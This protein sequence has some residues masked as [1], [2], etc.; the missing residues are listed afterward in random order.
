MKSP[1]LG[2]QTLSTGLVKNDAS[3]ENGSMD[4]TKRKVKGEPVQI[5]NVEEGSNEHI[6]TLD[7]DAL[8][9]VLCQKEIKDKPVCIVSVAG[10]FRKG[11]SFLLNFLLRFLRAKGSENWLRSSGDEFESTEGFDWKGGSNRVTTGILMWSE[12]FTIETSEGEVAVVLLDTQGC[13]DRRSSVKDGVT[14]FALS[15]LASSVLIYNLDDNIQEDDLE[16][17]DFLTEY[18]RLALEEEGEAPFQKLSLL[19]R[20]WACP[21]DYAY[22]SEGGE[23]YRKFQWDVKQEQNKDRREHLDKC[24]SEISCF[25]LPDPGKSV[26][27]NPGKSVNLNDNE[28]AEFLKHLQDFIPAIF[29]PEALKMKKVG[30]KVVKCKDMVHYF[31]TYMDILTG[32]DMPE[33]KS[34]LDV[35][36]EANNLVSKASA[37]DLYMDNMEEFCGGRWYIQKK[38]MDLE[39]ECNLE[40]A[41]KEFDSERNMGGKNCSKEY[42]DELTEEIEEAYLHF[43][44]NNEAR[45][46][47][48]PSNVFIMV[49]LSWGILYIVSQVVATSCSLQIATSCSLQ[50]LINCLMGIL[51]AVVI[52]GAYVKYAGKYPSFGWMLPSWKKEIEDV[53]HSLV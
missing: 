45:N 51:F 50:I 53:G 5:V 46:V 39:H 7:E 8:K 24:F 26:N 37:L 30:G 34:L 44:T 28:F 38:K 2:L 23:Q 29:A 22:G 4:H 40:L 32:D 16:H 25:L 48:K 21:N 11:K 35:T 18:G 36:I 1:F 10:A 47:F 3:V 42:R 13:F 9:R 15:L 31:K 6:F 19:V 52:I 27:I 49:S 41:Y 12:V 33:P 43:K 14:I 17:L 20:D